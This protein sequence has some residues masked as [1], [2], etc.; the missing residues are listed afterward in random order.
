MSWSTEFECD[1]CGR[2]YE[3]TTSD[4]R[5]YVLPDGRQATCRIHP[6]WCGTCGL[7][8][9]GEVVESLEE[10]RK[11]A[12]DP[13]SEGAR[14]IA[15][16]FAWRERRQ[17]PPRCLR[18]GSTEIVD[19]PEGTQAFQHPGCGGTLRDGASCIHNQRDRI[20]TYDVEGVP[21]NHAW[22]GRLR[23]WLARLMNRWVR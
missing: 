11:A 15:D 19:V 17:S 12:G 14:I 2:V 10:M 6:V 3:V 22:N 16:R 4:L 1:R 18:C 9:E 13:A 20:L 8:T 21:L 7:I 23:R 5:Y